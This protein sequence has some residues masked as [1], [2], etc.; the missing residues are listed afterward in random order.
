MLDV[1]RMRVLREVAERGSIAAAAQELAFTP[2]A[3]SQQIATLERETGVALVERGPR[4]LRLTE[5]GR[6]LVTHTDGILASLE[7]AEADVQAIAGVRAGILRLASFPTAYA[8]VMPPALV[9]FRRQH[10][11]V[12]LTLTEADPKASL[13]RVKSGELDLALAYEYDYVPAGHDDAL[14]EVDLFND[15]IRVLVPRS[16]PAARR[17]AARLEQLAGD[18]WIT[19]TARSSCHAFVTRACETAGFSPHI[20][21]ESDDYTV[22]QGLV[23]SG[24]GVALAPD[25]ALTSVHPNVVVRPLVLQPL[26]RRVFAVHRAGGRSPAIAAMLEVLTS[27]SSAWAREPRAAASAS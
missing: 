14:G 21:F 1:R 22:W 4:S 11:A 9:E 24:M 27:T 12:E 17:R 2:S 19:S 8:T 25:L 5:A 15:P 13:A 7:A 6:V 20:G 26:K 23:A 18:A 10:P 16:H 3:V